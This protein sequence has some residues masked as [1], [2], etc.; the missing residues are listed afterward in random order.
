MLFIENMV[1]QMDHICTSFPL[2][3]PRK[4]DEIV[5]NNVIKDPKQNPP[6]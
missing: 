1:K 5:H 2:N 6:K 4:H 3:N